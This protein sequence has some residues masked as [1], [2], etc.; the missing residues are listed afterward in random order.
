MLRLENSFWNMLKPGRFGNQNRNTIPSSFWNVVLRKISWTG[1]V[2]NEAVVV[3]RATNALHTAKV[4]VKKKV[5][6]RISRTYTLGLHALQIHCP[7]TNHTANPLLKH[8]ARNW[9]HYEL[10]ATYYY[11]L[12]TATY[13]LQHCRHHHLLWIMGIICTHSRRIIPRARPGSIQEAASTLQS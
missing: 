9:P 1:S 5:L 4:R 3:T 10:L 12:L 11:L 13:K 6:T 2:K 8:A 7:V